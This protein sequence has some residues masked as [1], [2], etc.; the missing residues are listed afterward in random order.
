VWIL[1][2]EA[3]ESSQPRNGLNQPAASFVCWIGLI[4]SRTKERDELVIE[5]WPKR[6]RVAL[7][8]AQRQHRTLVHLGQ[9]RAQL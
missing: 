2:T 4:A 3:W 1:Q 7:K 5:V 6:E 9:D 8:K